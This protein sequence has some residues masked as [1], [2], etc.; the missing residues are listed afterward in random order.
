MN[1]NHRLNQAE[2]S[3]VVGRL[4][5]AIAHE[6]RNPLNYINLTLDHLRTTLAPEDAGKRE[7]FGRL[8]AQLKTEVARINTRISEFL[9]FTRPAK[10]ELRPLDL[11]ATVADAL[12]LVEVQAEESGI[13][14]RI[15]SNGDLPARRRRCGV[16]TFR[17]HK[18]YHQRD[19][20]DGGRGRA[21]D[22][23]PRRRQRRARAH[24]E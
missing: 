1:S 19:A 8:T 13:E 16:F 24:R 21:F 20:V 7:L 11:R 9:K 14:T 4:A 5:S 2:R 10:L 12:S 22:H 17:L 3:A 23:P 15:E 18:P 6:V